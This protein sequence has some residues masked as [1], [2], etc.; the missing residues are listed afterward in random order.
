MIQENY[1]NTIDLANEQN[2]EMKKNEKKWKMIMICV[3]LKILVIMN[4]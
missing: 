2:N 3:A 4:Y 1:K